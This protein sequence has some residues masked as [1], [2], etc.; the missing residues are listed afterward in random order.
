[1]ALCF[2]RLDACLQESEDVRKRLSALDDELQGQRSVDKI[3]KGMLALALHKLALHIAL[4][5]AV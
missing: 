4:Q 1:M 3:L 5:M 2:Q